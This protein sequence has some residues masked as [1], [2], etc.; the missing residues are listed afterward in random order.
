MEKAT[1]DLVVIGGGPGGYATALYAA[2]AGMDVGLVEKHK[3]GGTCLHVGCVPAKQILESASVLRTVSHAA[4]FGVSTGEPEMDMLVMQQ[5]KQG[6]IDRLAKGVAGML[7]N[8]KVSVY[9]GLGTLMPQTKNGSPDSPANQNSPAN[10]TVAV[11]AD[12]AQADA[13]QEGAALAD[14]T[15][16]DN[17]SPAAGG[18][19]KSRPAIE[20]SEVIAELSAKNVV[21]ASGSVPRSL[22]LPGFEFDGEVVINSDHLLAIR[23][24]PESVAIVGG[25][26]IGCEFASLLSDFGAKVVLLE[27]LPSLLDATDPDVS[28]QVARSFKKRGIDVR[29]GVSVLGC[30]IVEASANSKSVSSKSSKSKSSKTKSAHPQSASHESAPA[31]SAKVLL[32]GGEEVA[33]SQVVVAVGRRPVSENLGFEEAGVEMEP[34]GHVA[35]DEF[36]RTSVPGIYAVG[37]LVS[38]P[39]L[40]HVGFAE[41]MLTVGHMLAES[42]EPLDYKRIPWGIYCRPEVA[43][44]GLTEPEAVEAGHEIAVSTHRFGGNSRAMIVGEAEGLMKVVAKK[45]PDGTAGQILGVHI[46]GPWATELLGQAYLSVNWE[47][48]VADIASLIQPHPTLSEIFGETVLSLTGRPLHG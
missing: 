48:E 1:H 15:Q 26:A 44:A 42:P 30:E 47:A 39:Q 21:L 4:D 35:V 40:A 31:K 8:R 37:D 10:H 27:A 24:V 5:R 34:G 43:F 38:T 36:C 46:V 13:T 20:N 14:N 25:G 16:E 29:T 7:K 11:L 33:V 22:P 41:G 19:A 9:S 32:E 12:T 28:K 17:A 45:K 3:L 23:E 2:A 18:S 6:V